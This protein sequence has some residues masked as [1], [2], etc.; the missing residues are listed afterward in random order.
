M[1]EY[2]D[3]KDSIR[4]VSDYPV[5]GVQFRDITT[6]LQKPHLFKKMINAMTSQWKPYQIDAILSIESRGFIMAG[7]LAYNL[8]TAFI[9]LRKPQKL[10]FNTH[11]VS[12]EL[13]YGATE[14]HIHTDALDGHTNLLI[15]D[16]LLATGG[17]V[18][19]ALDLVRNFE[20]KN[21]VGAGFV[22]NLPQLGGEKKLRQLEMKTKYLIEF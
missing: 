5:Q 7:A 11:S 21:I 19:A 20:E 1:K 2:Q 3:L 15:I 17:T 10:P 8:E 6:L 12:Y 22:I 9:P 18:I 14:M 16:D 13:E 4:T